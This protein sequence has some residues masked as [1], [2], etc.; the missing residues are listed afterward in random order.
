MAKRILAVLLAVMMLLGLTTAVSAAPTSDGAF[1]VNQTGERYDDAAEALAAAQAASGEPRVFLMKDYTGDIVIDDGLSHK[2]YLNGYTLTGS[3]KLING[4]LN[5]YEDSENTPDGPDSKVVNTGLPGEYPLYHENG[6]LNVYE[7]I[8]FEATEADGTAIYSKGNKVNILNFDNTSDGITVNGNIE[9]AAGGIITIEDGTYEGEILAAPGSAVSISHGSF[10]ID[11]T[12]NLPFGYA[13]QLNGGYYDIVPDPAITLSLLDTDSSG[14]YLLKTAEDITVFRA[15]LNISGTSKVIFTGETFK[16]AN[17]IDMQNVEMPAAGSDGKRFDGTFDGQN[18]VIRNV[19]INAP[20]S[21][22][23]GFFGNVYQNAVIK[24]VTF[25]NVTVNGGDYTGA[26][27][28]FTRAAEVDNVEITG[29][30]DISG[31]NYV[32][33]LVGGHYNNTEIT[34]CTVSGTGSI[35][36]D[37]AVAAILGQS[38]GTVSISGAEASGV[39]VEAE[40]GNVGGLIGLV[41]DGSNVTLADNAVNNVTIVTAPGV[42]SAGTLIGG[43]LTG[44][45]AID[46]TNTATNTTVIEE[47]KSISLANVF[48]YFIMLKRT[49]EITADVTEGGTISFTGNY[50]LS[51]EGNALVQ[52]KRDITYTIEA[53]EGYILTDVLVDG[54]SVGAVSEYTFDNVGKKHSISAVFTAEAAA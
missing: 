31:A 7:N 33:G 28:G 52:F 25:E 24:D 11:P 42:E 46:D 32:G 21:T 10:K 51:D 18:H 47:D 22:Y 48:F 37:S 40:N 6:Q 41:T 16:L 4:L 1:Y 39:R 26:L 34:D 2:I 14:A 5:L 23:V 53:D 20:G 36:G 44:D 50:K 45:V 15:L 54:E 3:I 13:A 49:Y 9:A 30:I 35:T 12:A 8:T 27:I 29:D 19:N 38:S 43:V 17:D